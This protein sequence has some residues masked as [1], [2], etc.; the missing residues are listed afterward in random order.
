MPDINA[1]ACVAAC[2]QNFQMREK[3]KSYEMVI[4]TEHSGP[5][6]HVAAIPGNHEEVSML[7]TYLRSGGYTVYT[8]NPSRIYSIIIEIGDGYRDMK[9]GERDWVVSKGDV[10]GGKVRGMVPCIIGRPFPGIER[11]PEPDFYVFALCFDSEK[12]YADDTEILYV[13]PVLER[14]TLKSD[15]PAL[16]AGVSFADDPNGNVGVSI[17]DDTNANVGVSIADDPSEK[18]GNNTSGS[19]DNVGDAGDNDD[20]K[21][22]KNDN[23]ATDPTSSAIESNT[24]TLLEYFKTS[25]TTNPPDINLGADINRDSFEEIFSLPLLNGRFFFLHPIEFKRGVMTLLLKYLSTKKLH[26]R[27]QVE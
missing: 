10:V 21:S 6:V 27:D 19:N 18:N 8:N 1:A 7:K 9:K 20:E 17:A 22:H 11:E 2:V 12:G 3:G 16:I 4:K 23:N 14:G 5:K 13:G 25:I 26:H 15:L 24:Q